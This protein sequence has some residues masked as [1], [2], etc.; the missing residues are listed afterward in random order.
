MSS[1]KCSNCGLVRFANLEH[2]NRCRGASDQGEAP[3]RA[4]RQPV[5]AWR[6]RWWL[7]KQLGVPLD[8]CCI[9]CGAFAD[10]SQKPVSVEA[11]SAWSFLTQLFG[12]HVFRK[13]SFEVPLCRRH[14]YG[15][16]KLVVGP[17]IV[18]GLIC[19]LGCSGMQMSSILPVVVFMIGFFVL[20]LGGIVYLIRRETVQ[21][22]KYNKP[23]V[24]LWGVHRSYLERLPSWSARRTR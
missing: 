15:M 13:I 18:G 5:G 14:R 9:K 17:I 22:W 1:I 23:Y 20:A 4:H 2:C 7:V 19:L 3:Q 12:V 24:W 16:D 10:V 21:V 8:D 6:D 11:L